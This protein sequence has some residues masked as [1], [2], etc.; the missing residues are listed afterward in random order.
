[1]A[2]AVKT[3]EIDPENDDDLKQLCTG[4]K[5]AFVLQK[6]GLRL[7]LNGEDIT[8]R[9]RTAEITMLASAVS[10]RQVVRECLLEMQ[11]NLG[12]EKAVVFEG[13]DMGTVVFPQADLKFFL[14][15]NAQT[16]ALRRYD[17]IKSKS[18]QTLEDVSL[19]IRRRDN[20][21]STRNLAPLKPA[22]DAIMVDSTDLSVSEVV[23]LMVSHING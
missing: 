14:S 8:D 11:R 16:R 17:E 22:S 13:R 9:I 12:K 20:D 10:A 3:S 21:D 7:L 4:L 1:V 15:A 23:E 6:E 18:S 2:L 19:D 5:L